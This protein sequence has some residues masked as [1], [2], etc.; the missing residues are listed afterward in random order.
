MY[1][2]QRMN[3]NYST[4]P[5]SPSMTPTLDRKENDLQQTQTQSDGQKSE[6]SLDQRSEA[7]ETT[8]S[9]PVKSNSKSNKALSF[10]KITLKLTDTSGS[11]LSMVISDDTHDAHGIIFVF[12]SCDVEHLKESFKNF[13]NLL[14]CRFVKSTLKPI[15]LLGNKQD[16]KNAKDM[17]ELYE[18]LN[19]EKLYSSHK[20][21]T[22]T[23][24]L[25][26]NLIKLFVT[27]SNGS[28]NKIDKGLK[29]GINW[30]VQ[31]IESGYD[32]ITAQ[33]LAD[34]V[35]F[36]Q[37]NEEIMAERRAEKKKR[38]A[39]EHNS[40]STS[41]NGEDGKEKEKDHF[42]VATKTPTIMPKSLAA[43][44]A[45]QSKTPS[46]KKSISSVLNDYNEFSQSSDSVED[47]FKIGMRK[48][49][50]G[51]GEDPEISP[52]KHPLQAKLGNMGLGTKVSPMPE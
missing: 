32:K 12:D 25:D 31:K 9:E 49:S 6:K 21:L 41:P 24:P 51:S 7:A 22:T 17:R 3:G 44:N 39:E 38:L 29:T 28:S 4:A 8:Q 16:L 14:K 36:R 42:V 19:L 45:I 13:K 1:K 37:E 23:G 15:L 33:I 30:L 48:P 5:E 40:G 35:I 20:N 43:A 26:Q 50:G 10:R 18:Y 27:S 52:I 46:S 34:I 2:N 47:F 11:M